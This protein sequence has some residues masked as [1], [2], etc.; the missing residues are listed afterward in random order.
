MTFLSYSASICRV[1]SLPDASNTCPPL[2]RQASRS[3]WHTPISGWRAHN[4]FT[5]GS[6]SIAVCC[7]WPL[8]APR[9]TYKVPAGTGGKTGGAATGG[10]DSDGATFASEGGWDVA[11]AFSAGRASA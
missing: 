4:C 2:A 7:N 1:I 9:H 11:A 8:T 3:Y 6:Y 10:T 5:R